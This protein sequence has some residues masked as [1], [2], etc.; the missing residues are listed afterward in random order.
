MSA[1]KRSKRR[2]AYL[3]EFD[4]RVSKDIDKLPKEVARI[5]VEKC[6]VL[7]ENPLY[8]PNIKRL[9]SNLYRMEVLRVWRVAYTVEGSKVL[10]VLVGHRKDC[11]DRLSRRM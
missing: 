5:I 9:S 3:V 7:E 10:I 2:L 4:K 11:Y 6:S 1:S 8:G